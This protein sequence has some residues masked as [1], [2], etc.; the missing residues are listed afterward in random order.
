[1][2]PYPTMS[3]IRCRLTF[4]ATTRASLAALVTI[5][6]AS[7]IVGV[8]PAQASREGCPGW[9]SLQYDG[10]ASARTERCRY[11]KETT[12]T[13]TYNQFLERKSD[14]TNVGCLKPP[15][16]LRAPEK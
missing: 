13:L 6:S 14:F 5:I 11:A 12:V 3:Q 4:R 16:Q 10:S 7:A 2:S 8:A 1:M 15:W 9:S